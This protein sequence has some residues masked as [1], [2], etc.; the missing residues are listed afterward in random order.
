MKKIRHPA[1]FNQED[2]FCY[3]DASKTN[4]DVKIIIQEKINRSN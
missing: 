3:L 4:P 1:D 2:N